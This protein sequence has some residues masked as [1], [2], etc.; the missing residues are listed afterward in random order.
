M[1]AL[2]LA[3]L[4]IVLALA[5]F[6]R[7]YVWRTERCHPPVGEMVEVNGLRLHALRVGEPKPDVP[8]LVFI[9]GASGNLHDQFHAFASHLP[10]GR[11]AI[12]L[13]RPGQGH[14]ERGGEVNDTPAGQADTLAALLDAWHIDRAVVV[15]H[16]YGGAVAASFA[17]R[18]PER[19]AGMV[20]V[21]AATHP[22]PG[23]KTSWY[24][25]LMRRRP[26]LAHVFAQT[27]LVPLGLRRMDCALN[28]VFSPQPVPNSYYE[29][30]AT[31][32]A[33]RPAAFLAN[34]R[35][36][37]SLY[38]YFTAVAPRY[39]EIEAPTVVITGDE[40]AIVHGPWHSEPM[41][42]A[43]PHSRLVVVPG[44][45]HKP[46]YYATN[47]VLKGIEAVTKS[48]LADFKPTVPVP[49]RR[50]VPVPPEAIEDGIETTPGTAELAGKV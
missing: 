8:P 28:G 3:P 36:V 22:W 39:E 16:S 43:L 11:E 26:W 48:A 21:S 4:L 29:R 27:L 20:L 5:L 9:H 13:D 1:T 6:T 14:S 25:E 18:H 49:P 50:A 23:G 40:D 34:A 33:I 46:D 30:S 35:D 41:H 44:L 24:Y 45:G 7:A 10:L 12:F 31:A 42:R 19:T 47:L 32:L 38:R 2:L 17:L 15:G 37:T